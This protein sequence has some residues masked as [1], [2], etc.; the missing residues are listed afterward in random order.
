M[1]H[2]LEEFGGSIGSEIDDRDDLLVWRGDVGYLGGMKSNV[3]GHDDFL[4]GRWFKSRFLVLLLDDVVSLR[5]KFGEI[6]RRVLYERN[7]AQV[8]WS[9]HFPLV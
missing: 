1:I 2:Q 6:S 7:G 9:I 8:E 4:R 3:Q 5:V